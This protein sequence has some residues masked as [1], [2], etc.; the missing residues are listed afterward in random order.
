MFDANTY[1]Y[2]LHEY[3]YKLYK[4]CER[5]WKLYLDVSYE[6]NRLLERIKEME[7]KNEN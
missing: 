1:R 4:E 3:T 6:R 2:G 7:R 5:L